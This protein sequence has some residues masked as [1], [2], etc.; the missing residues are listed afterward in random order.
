ME[1]QYNK[2]ENAQRGVHDTEIEMMHVNAMLIQEK[3]QSYN[4]DTR[5]SSLQEETSSLVKDVEGFKRK[6]KDSEEKFNDLEIQFLTVKEMRDKY[7][8]MLSE[9]ENKLKEARSFNNNI[10]K[11]KEEIIRK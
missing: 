5:I 3:E 7:E 6:L 1:Y 2:T 4:K 9:E 10:L 8:L 11:E